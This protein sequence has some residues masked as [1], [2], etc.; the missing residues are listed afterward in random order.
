MKCPFCFSGD[1]YV[2]D[3]RLSQDGMYVRRR[4][5][6]TVC[7]QRFSTLETL[8]YHSIT[9][10]KKNGKKEAFS[11]EKLERSINTALSSMAIENSERKK[12]FTTLKLHLF[13]EAGKHRNVLTTTMIGDEALKL[14][15][16]VSPIA[17]I[18]FASVYKEFSDV[19]QIIAEIKRLK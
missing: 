8:E 5:E 18:R 1:T 19:K 16:E 12:L 14:L 11:E 13:Q 3:S 6:C 7:K 4:R 15:K 2:V 17:Y 9:V 10:I